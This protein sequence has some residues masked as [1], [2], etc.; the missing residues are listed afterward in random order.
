MYEVARHAG[1]A[2]M[3]V[4]RVLSG[5][6][7]VSDH[8]RK[9]VLSAIRKLR[10]TPNVT[11]RNLASASAVHIGLLYTNPSAGYLGEFLVGVLGRSSQVGCQ[12]LLE[13]C[14]DGSE[15]EAIRRL[16]A[17]SVDG[18]IVPPPLC[19]STQAIEILR[20]SKTPFVT[21][22]TGE[23]RTDCLC[24][25]IDNFRAAADM[26][27]YLVSLGHTKVGFIVGAAN[28]TASAQRYA[29]FSAALL[30]AG[31]QLHTEWVKMGDFTYRSGLTAAEQLL[32]VK[33]RPTAIFAS[34]DDMAAAAMA[35][36]HRM[37]LEIPEDITVVGFDDTP[38]ASTIWPTLTTVHQPIA[39]MAGRALELLVQDVRRR[40]LG[41]HAPPGHLTLE[42]SLMKRESSGPVKQQARQLQT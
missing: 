29:G 22:A 35:V 20:T 26:T 18:I 19:D 24:V 41:E 33:P 34:N 9:T 17:D 11:A 13:K 30:E 1:V 23:T 37:R 3:T 2:P 38:L 5:H 4:S 15:R 36:A 28:Q 21:V 7:H 12:V 25:R 31:L 27:R 32:S 14:A 42:Y 16:I 6:S 40:R 8:T 39:S 10:Y